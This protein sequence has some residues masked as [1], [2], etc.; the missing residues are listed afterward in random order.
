MTL[1]INIFFK[2]GCCLYLF[3]Y[4]LALLSCDGVS[5]LYDGDSSMWGG[6]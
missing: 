1:K 2:K 4:P 5:A 3:P 6:F